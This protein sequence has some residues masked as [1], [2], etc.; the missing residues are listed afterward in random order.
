MKFARNTGQDATDAAKGFTA[1]MN[2][3][4]LTA[5][6][7]DMQLDL[8]NKT[9]QDFNI[10]GE[11]LNRG[12]TRN[13]ATLQS[14]GFNISEST[15]LMGRLAQG[16]ETNL[17]MF[18]GLGSALGSLAKREGVSIQEAFIKLQADV[19]AATTAAEK[20]QIATEALGCLLYTSPSPRD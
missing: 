5:E 17:R 4:G 14:L 2:A 18:N 1:Q 3:F 9:Q 11:L 10:S 20:Q 15:V 19:D 16:G 13:S 6:Q 7:G 8:L 12:L